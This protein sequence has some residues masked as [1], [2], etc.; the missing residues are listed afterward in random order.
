M[1]IERPDLSK[2]EGRYNN[3][4]MTFTNEMRKPCTEKLKSLG[5]IWIGHH[6]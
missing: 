1:G 6:T 5:L 4:L 2:P 3:P